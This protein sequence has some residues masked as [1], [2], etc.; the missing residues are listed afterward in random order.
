M[1]ETGLAYDFGEKNLRMTS[2]RNPT[3]TTQGNC[4]GMQNVL[5]TGNPVLYYALTIGLGAFLLFQVQPVIAKIILP[6]FGGA[7][8]VWTTCLLFFQITLLLG[9]LYAHALVRYLAPRMQLLVHATLLLASVVA[10]PIYPNLKWKPDGTD[11]PSLRILGL[12]A[13]TVG[14]PYFMLATTSPLLQAW[15]SLGKKGTIPYRLYALSNAGS[16]FAL[17]S[18]P[19]LFEPVFTT[20]QQANI[21]SFAYT[22]FALLCGL[23]ALRFVRRAESEAL[24][25]PEIGQRPGW[26]D[27]LIW[28]A[29]AGCASMLLLAITNHMSQNIAAIPF[30]WVL[31]LS[32]YLLTFILCFE[33][34]GWYRRKS[35]LRLLA[36]GMA[37]MAIA[38]R[39]EQDGAL[40]I[41]VLL[42]LFALGLFTCCMVCHGEL[43]RLKP[44]LKY[45]THFYLMISA[46]GALGGVLVGLLAPHIFN[47]F[48]ELPLGLSLC[49]V[50]VLFVLG[51]DD[52]IALFRD[53]RRPVCWVT[54]ALAIALITEFGLQIRGSQRGARVLARNFYGGL[55]VRDAALNSQDSVRRL[56]HGTINHGEEYLSPARRDWPTTYYGPRA[57][58]GL[59]IRDKQ[60]LGPVRV[61]VIG[62]G[63]GTI[64]AYGRAGDYFRFYEI[65]PLVEQLARGEFRFLCDSK[66]RTDITLG[67]ARLSLERQEPQ[68]FDVLVVDAFSSD[69]IPVHLLTREA[70]E[71]YFHHLKA[72]GTLAFH[73]SNR[74]LDLQPVLREEAKASGKVARLVETPG[75]PPHDVF[76]ATWGYSS[77][78]QHLA[79]AMKSRMLREI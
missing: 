44:N 46:G 21:W 43:A 29:L 74:Y 73:I 8:A 62:L 55:Q 2:V 77:S 3:Q 49:T 12:L 56:K 34:R 41:R 7:A 57:G 1:R 10:L 16:M 6:W 31:P 17:L 76:A 52:E 9:Y 13:V 22:A 50:L 70:M 4:Y 28:M 64:A 63:V 5:R 38:M 36:A 54:A 24:P 42:P 25:Q 68:N 51:R 37:G 67:D 58:A 14:L 19:A 23:T 69:S 45:L 71:L 39:I 27:Y 40:P 65:N 11:D 75:D 53:W 60:K 33:G 32:I 26:R 15:Y 30:L 79:S 61:G 78:L 20:H 72:D 18:Y 59:A 35:Y 66:A 48:Y 47:A